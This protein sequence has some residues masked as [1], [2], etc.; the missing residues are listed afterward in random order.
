MSATAERT[1]IRPDGN[2]KVTGTGRYTADLTVAGQVHA[3][4]RYADHTRARILSIDT[5]R[6]RALPG[7]LAVV[8]HEDVPDVLYGQLVKDRRLFAKDEVRYEADVIAGVAALTPEIANEAVELI[9]VE[10]EPMPP[11]T[12]PEKALEPD[13]PLVHADWASYEADDGMVRDG[14]VLGHSTIVKG[15]ADAAMAEANVVVRSRYVADGSH[16]VPIEPRAIVAQWQ[17]DRL[18]VWSS[19]SDAVHSPQ[20]RRR[21][22]RNPGV[23]RADHR[24]PT[25]R[26]LWLQVRLPLRGARRGAGA[27]RG[28]AG[29][30]RVLARGGVH[31]S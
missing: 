25:G 5:S 11:V 1:F 21:H 31:R 7:V 15:D 9:E 6:A 24:S 30:A 20:R 10:Y 27:R 4:F 28:T 18:T 19:T 13:A 2:E 26:W 3:R 29:K 17:G 12:D 22:A 8:T 16:G 14:N 23:E